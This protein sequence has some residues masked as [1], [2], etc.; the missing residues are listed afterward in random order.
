MS[1]TQ[2]VAKR[3]T[4]AFL[5]QAIYISIAVVLGLAAVTLVIEDVLIKQALRGE[6][7]FYWERVT[8]KHDHT[9]PETRNM[10]SYRDGHGDG[11]PADLANLELGFHRIEEPSK[12]LAL[13]TERDGDRLY[14][15]FD[16]ARVDWLITWFGLVPLA[17]VLAGVY[18][19]L[20][21][22]Y[23]V[24]SRA[25]SPIVNLANRVKQLD[26]ANPDVDLFARGSTG[27]DVDE[28]ILTLNSAMEDLTQRLVEFVKREFDFTRDASHELRSPLTVIK[29][30][31]E[32]L[33]GTELNDNQAKNLAR[34]QKASKDMEELTEAFLLLARESNQ[35]LPSDWVNINEL[36]HSEV[37]RAQILIGEKDVVIHEQASA[38]MT[39]NAPEK[40]LASVI[41]NLL[42]NGVNYT[43]EGNVSVSVSERGVIIEDSGPGMDAEELK[44]VF[45]PF[46]RGKRERQRGG[47]GVGLTIV[48]R[49][50]D[51]FGWPLEIDSTVGVGTTVQVRLPQAQPIQS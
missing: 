46:N 11:V 1:S 6:A 7:E 16:T 20:F 50:C 4:K 47:F 12:A 19:A 23:R 42:R 27:I 5:L 32:S 3:L 26:P 38:Q 33:T 13:I 39:I 43:D 51:R 28:E 14:Q 29:I 44:Q 45:R 18:M 25:V 30:A 35:S 48:K 37:D 40:V 21:Q 34:I 15:V 9:L 49:L 36:V 10:V 31:A 41:G 17:T 8:T 22:A 2:G 24:S